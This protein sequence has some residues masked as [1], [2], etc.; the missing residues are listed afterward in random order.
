MDLLS[1]PPPVIIIEGCQFYLL[2]ISGCLATH[3]A[4]YT[5]ALTCTTLIQTLCLL[6]VAW[7]EVLKCKSNHGT[8][9]VRSPVYLEK[10]RLFLGTSKALDDLVYG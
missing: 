9:L 5:I 4:T 8:L 6:G 3:K 1:L 10:A 7:A 2:N